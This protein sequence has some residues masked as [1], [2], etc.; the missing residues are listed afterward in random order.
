[1]N[2]RPSAE[3]RALVQ[4]LQKGSVTLVIS[5]TSV[6]LDVLYLLAT[7]LFFRGGIG[8]ISPINWR[9]SSALITSSIDHPFVVPTSMYSMN[10]IAISLFEKR[11]TRSN[12]SSSFEFL[13]T[14]VLIF[15]GPKPTDSAA[16]IPAITEATV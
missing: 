14:T 13:F 10:R 6:P 7:S 3:I 5:P 2:N 8:V 9:I 1:M 4:L 11:S 16:S 12:I 15:I